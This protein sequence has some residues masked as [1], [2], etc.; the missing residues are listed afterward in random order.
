MTKTAMINYIEE[1]GCVVD[2][3]RKYLMRKSREYI[4]RLYE[5]AKAYAA[6]K[7]D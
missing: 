6:K 1:T 3:D 2:F 7:E 4:V 5:H